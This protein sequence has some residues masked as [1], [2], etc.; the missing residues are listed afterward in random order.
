MEAVGK[1]WVV[2]VND[3]LRKDV[4]IMHIIQMWFLIAISLW[5]GE[6][7]GAA[8]YYSSSNISYSE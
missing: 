1:G 6:V 5:P 7:Q 8:T 2:A 3:A 4:L